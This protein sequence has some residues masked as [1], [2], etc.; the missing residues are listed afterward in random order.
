[1]WRAGDRRSAGS[2]AGPSRR[3][4]LRARA[5]PAQGDQLEALR[6]GGH[7]LQPDSDLRL[8][9]GGIRLLCFR[10]YLVE[11]VSKYIVRCG[12]AFRQSSRVLKAAFPT[13]KLWKELKIIDSR[14]GLILFW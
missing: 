10:H 12:I 2:L 14:Y 1:M 3:V 4:A 7:V 6:A 13:L 8:L 5:H 11:V 9:R